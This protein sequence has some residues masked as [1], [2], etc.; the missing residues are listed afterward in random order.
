MATRPSR[1]PSARPASMA[2]GHGHDWRCSSQDVPTDV[3]LDEDDEL[4]AFTGSSLAGLTGSDQ[5]GVRVSLGGASSAAD[6][7]STWTHSLAAPERDSFE[8][9]DD[10]PFLV[11][12]TATY[13]ARNDHRVSTAYSSSTRTSSARTSMALGIEP[14]SRRP[15]STLSSSSLAYARPTSELIEPSSRLNGRPASSLTRDSSISARSSR[16]IT[17]TSGFMAVP[18]IGEPDGELDLSFQTAPAI[19]HE[20]SPAPTMPR[21]K[22][23]QPPMPLFSSQGAC[24]RL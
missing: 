5:S 14:V 16:T 22:R 24:T 2:A 15:I 6:R 23:A 11:P 10:D 1:G 21:G 9:D 18:E 7:R 17:E 20:P 12:S 4:T 19:S 8:R 3:P 13:A